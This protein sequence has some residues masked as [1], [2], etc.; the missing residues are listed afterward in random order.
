MAESD[1]LNPKPADATLGGPLGKS[2]NVHSF[3]T[4]AAP[5]ANAFL[6]RAM[7]APPMVA[8]PSGEI[9]LG[10]ELAAARDQ[11]AQMA[12]AEGGGGAQQQ[13]IAD[14][15]W[16]EPKTDRLSADEW[17]RLAAESDR[18]AANLLS[19]DLV[20]RWDRSQRSFMNQHQRGS[21]Y[22]SKE[23]QQR[24][25]HFRPK[26]RTRVRHNE[27]SAAEAFFSNS[28]AVRIAAYDGGDALQARAARFVD[29]LVNYHLEETIDWF[30]T[31]CG[32][33]QV[34][35][36]QGIVASWQSWDYAERRIMR[37]VPAMDP[38]TGQPLYNGVTGEPA[39]DEVPDIDILRDRPRI[40]LIPG[41]NLRIDPSADWRNAAQ[42]SPYL[43]VHVPMVFDD[44]L[45]MMRTPDPKTGRPAWID[46]PEEIIFQAQTMPAAGHQAEQV[47]RARE[48]RNAGADD[49][50]KRPMNPREYQIVW[51]RR[52]ILRRAGQ[53]WYFWT[54]GENTLLTEPM[55]I[56]EA[57]PAFDGQRPVVIGSWNLEAF[58][59]YPMS[60][61]EAVYPVQQQINDLHNLRFD[62]TR[63]NIIGRVKVKRG[64]SFDLDAW[65]N[66]VPGGAVWVDEMTDIEHD[67][68][69]GMPREAFEEQDR[70]NADFDDVT[71]GFSGGSVM[72]N[73]KLGETVGG[74][75]LLSNS[76]N[77]VQRY[78]LRIFTETWVQPVLRQVQAMVKT[79][80]TD[81]ER[82]ATAAR[83]A[84]LDGADLEEIAEAYGIP[85]ESVIDTL[86]AQKQNLKVQV[87][88]GSLD[89][90]T[91]LQAF[92]SIASGFQKV[93]GA[94]K[95]AKALDFREWTTEQFGIFGYAD[96]DRFLAKDGEDADPEKAELKQALDE[97][98]AEVERLKAGNE[99]KE[100]VAAINAMGR[101]AAEERRAAAQVLAAAQ[102]DMDQQP[103]GE[104]EAVDSILRRIE[105]S[106]FP[107]APMP[108]TPEDIG[109][110]MPGGPMPQG[111]PMPPPGMP[112]QGP[113]PPQAQPPMPAGM[114]PQPMPGA[115]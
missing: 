48:Q 44:V 10:A 37:M 115:P 5:P 78:D 112:S 102:K 42:T 56:E 91:K 9:V 87:G 90:A 74:M 41:E 32:A 40:D 36:V 111:G 105:A 31:L 66:A 94:E 95:T 43:F 104:T 64:K 27:A 77:L 24:S 110:P 14:K 26:T 79:F 108:P 21:K 45:A 67:R 59:V 76:A 98:M 61:V 62:Q 65:R 96:G 53:D 83:V 101:V 4:P 80:E 19:T 2:A 1:L 106:G 47:R 38:M 28:D 99:T 11:I 51:P 69:Q 29:H 114:M 8:P 57:F 84:D 33:A 75:Q 73:R 30:L 72:T 88:I 16:A 97:A 46:V 109:A 55:P 50:Q 49:P 52:N 92:D 23:Y 12:P 25:R 60:M 103:P 22:E 68:P 39:Y 54:I 113:M 86:L 85:P 100:R 13:D 17:V 93:F 3:D 107:D 89:P 18:S 71:G 81:P 70:L 63:L 82:L 20:E 7:T 58:K 6:P 34:A 35:Q 15:T